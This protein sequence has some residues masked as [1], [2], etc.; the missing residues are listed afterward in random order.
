[1]PSVYAANGNSSDNA[2]TKTNTTGEL[3]PILKIQP[4]DRGTFLRLVQTAFRGTVPG[5]PITAKLRSAANTQL[6]VN[7]KIALEF[8]G[9]GEPGRRVVSDRHQNIS[10]YRN[11]SLTEQENR[12]RIDSAKHQLEQGP[13]AEVTVGDADAL[14]VSIEASAQISHADSEIFLSQNNVKLGQR[15]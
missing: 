2:K 3:T 9:A 15:A 4:A 11:N 12:D 6:P 5:I 1:M 14:F 7:T 8:S 13:N 10:F